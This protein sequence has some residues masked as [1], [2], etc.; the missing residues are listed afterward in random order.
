MVLLNQR[1]HSE[2]SN[3]DEGSTL[4]SG[5]AGTGSFG[6]GQPSGADNLGAVGEITF[7]QFAETT[8]HAQ[9]PKAKSDDTEA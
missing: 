5:T 6:Q 4:E 9:D 8:V 3:Q 1:I 2:D 7:I